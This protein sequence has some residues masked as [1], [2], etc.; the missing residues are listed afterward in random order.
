MPEGGPVYMSAGRHTIIVVLEDAPGKP[1][2]IV[3]V[4]LWNRL[5][6]SLSESLERDRDG[7]I[8]YTFRVGNGRQAEDGIHT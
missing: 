3:R 4:P 8:R 5:A 2:K 1:S 7:P 6:P